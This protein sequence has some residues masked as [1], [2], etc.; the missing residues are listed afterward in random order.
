MLARDPRVACAIAQAAPVDFDIAN[1]APGDDYATVTDAKRIWG[2][3]YG[4]V[5]YASR[6]KPAV[7]LLSGAGDET[8]PPSRALRYVAR[9]PHAANITMGAGSQ[10]WLHTHVSPTALACAGARVHRLLRAAVRGQAAA[11]RALGAR[12]QSC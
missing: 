2:A 10:Q 8:A 6:T 12:D 4:P 11:W 3:Q 9:A 1:P 7:L 5:R